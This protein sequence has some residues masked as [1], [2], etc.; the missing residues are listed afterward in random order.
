MSQELT[1]NNKD[2]DLTLAINYD[3]NTPLLAGLPNTISQH[4]IS[5]GKRQ[6]ADVPG[7]KIRLTI[8]LSNNINQIPTLFDVKMTETW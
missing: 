2:G 6:K 1:F 3:E 8:V 5:K 4:K 7:S